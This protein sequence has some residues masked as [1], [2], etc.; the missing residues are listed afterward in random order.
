MYIALSSAKSLTKFLN[1]CR[2][3]C[4]YFGLS[5]LDIL[6][7]LDQEVTEAIKKDWIEWIY[8]QQIHPDPFNPG[9][10]EVYTALE[11]Y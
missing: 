3:T 5:G 8:A 1:N 4:A 2:M 6:G 7:V 10:Y 11:A 9:M